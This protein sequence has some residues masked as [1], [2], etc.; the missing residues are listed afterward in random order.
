M[1]QQKQPSAKSPDALKCSPPQC[2]HAQCLPP[3]SAPCAEPYS[4]DRSSCPPSAPAQCAACP[5]R[6]GP[7]RARRQPR[8]V[9][10]GTTYHCQEEEC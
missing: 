5:K 1:S 3:C 7:K 6:A 9:S 10:G 8:C 2:P 4:G